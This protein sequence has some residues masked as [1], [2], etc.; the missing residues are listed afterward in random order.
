MRKP[1]GT[2][3]V[4]RDEIERRPNPPGGRF[5]EV[6]RARVIVPRPL[7]TPL[8][9]FC[10]DTT[11]PVVALTFDDGPHPVHT[12]RVLDALTAAGATATFFVLARQVREH[13]EIARRIV[14]EGHEVA[15][16]GDD[17]RSLFTLEPWEARRRLRRARREVEALAGVRLRLYRPPYGQKT[18]LHGA[19]VG[20]LGLEVIQWSGAAF[21][22]L[23]DT[24]EAIAERALDAVFPGAI[25]LLHDNRGD[26]ETLKPH[27]VEPAFHR[28]EST[29]RIL[30]G[31]D[32]RGFRTATVGQLLRDYRE[33]RSFARERERWR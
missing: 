17:H 1:S 19:A 22:W 24:E 18:A 21:D 6:A 26:P 16:H 4:P 29:R 20:S 5:A 30:A 10:V 31:L 25:L 14:A 7:R 33:V 13:P 9:V 27:E 15:L 3:L 11:D 12:P 32:E 28:G 23:D 8:G 2:L